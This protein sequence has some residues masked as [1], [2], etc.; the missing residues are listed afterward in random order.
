MD[1]VTQNSSA[2]LRGNEFSGG[3]IQLQPSKDPPSMLDVFKDREMGTAIFANANANGQATDEL[4]IIYDA[5]LYQGASE[6]TTC[7]YLILRRQCKREALHRPY[8]GP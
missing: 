7:P 3:F 1:A 2:Y 6:L 5:D 8:D 4:V